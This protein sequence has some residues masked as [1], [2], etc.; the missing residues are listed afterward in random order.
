MSSVGYLGW[1]QGRLSLLSCSLFC[2]NLTQK[3]TREI[4]TLIY[5]YSSILEWFILKSD[6]ND[7][8]LTLK[9]GGTSHGTEVVNSPQK[10]NLEGQVWRWKE[11][12]RITSGS[13][14][15]NLVLD[16]SFGKVSIKTEKTGNV[17]QKWRWYLMKCLIF[18]LLLLK[19]VK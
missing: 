8:V 19:D 5:F 18:W 2:A 17:H 6:L 4:T 3:Q 11:G 15:E 10:Q 1:S 7:F 16:G 13:T 14:D 12:E 9:H